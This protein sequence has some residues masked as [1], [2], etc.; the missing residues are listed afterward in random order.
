MQSLHKQALL[1]AIDTKKII[2]DRDFLSDEELS[3]LDRIDTLL[4]NEQHSEEFADF[5]S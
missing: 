2:E 5:L 4:E 3:I 1:L